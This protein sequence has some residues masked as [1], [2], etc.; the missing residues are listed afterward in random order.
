M[1]NA[2]YQTEIEAISA[3]RAKPLLL[4]SIW[5]RQLEAFGACKLYSKSIADA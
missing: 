2:N 1:L 4:N 3:S 5:Q